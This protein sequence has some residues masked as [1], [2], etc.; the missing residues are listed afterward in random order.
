[1]MIT[2]RLYAALPARYAERR[3]GEPPAGFSAGVPLGLDLPPATTVAALYQ[4]LGL[5]RREV[6]T[7]FVNGRSRGPDHTL[8]PGDQVGLFPPVGG[9]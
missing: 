1:M 3:P 4:K 2:V 9:G 8:G 6:L 7:A 5:H